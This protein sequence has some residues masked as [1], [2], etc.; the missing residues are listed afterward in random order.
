MALAQNAHHFV[1]DTINRSKE[2]K[3]T[4][5]EQWNFRT[6]KGRQLRKG[7]SGDLT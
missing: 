4:N 5:H 2:K 6:G 3:K 7:E 1:F